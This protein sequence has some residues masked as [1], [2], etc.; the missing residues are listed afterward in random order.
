MYPLQSS[1]KEE[2]ECRIEMLLVNY[3]PDLKRA[4]E[5]K[6]EAEIQVSRGY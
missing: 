2:G 6:P 5:T 3:S 1:G 4:E